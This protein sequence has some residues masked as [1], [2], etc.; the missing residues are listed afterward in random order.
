MPEIM[1]TCDDCGVSEGINNATLDLF[2]RGLVTTAS[3][4]T[5]YPALEHACKLFLDY[6]EL[7]SGIHLN[8]TEGKPVLDNLSLLLDDEGNFLPRSNLIWRSLFPSNSLHKEVRRELK[9]QFEMLLDYG[10]QP[11]HV[12]THIHFHAISPYQEIVQELAGQYNCMWIRT[13]QVSRTLMPFNPIF[14]PL[15]TNKFTSPA[16]PNYL[17]PLKYWMQQS[18]HQVAGRIAN[19]SGLVELI[20]HP[21]TRQDKTFPSNMTY[22]PS[23]RHQE[24][25]FL[26]SLWE[27]A[28]FQKLKVSRFRMN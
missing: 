28:S 6:P 14:N 21:S 15:P 10:L 17:V 19:L 27:T 26:E 9:A 13:Y 1:I 4:M 5:N 23:E 12:T 22:L 2:E 11:S 8:L 20:V 16:I 3:I 24:Q 7:E 18:A 25:L